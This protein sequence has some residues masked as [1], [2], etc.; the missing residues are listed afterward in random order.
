MAGGGTSRTTARVLP[1]AA[2]PAAPTAEPVSADRGRKNGTSS[3]GKPSP[4]Q[5]VSVT[6]GKHSQGWRL[7][8]SAHIDS[9]RLSVLAVVRLVTRRPASSGSGNGRFPGRP[10]HAA[11]Y[12][13]LP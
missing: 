10:R 12:L 8:N 1:E 7:E 2:L 6:E 13:L 5:A 11:L 4:T 3:R 9:A